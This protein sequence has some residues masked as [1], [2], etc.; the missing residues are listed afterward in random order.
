[1]CSTDLRIVSSLLAGWKD[2]EAIWFVTRQE[3][4]GPFV[5]MNPYNSAVA[6]EVRGKHLFPWGLSIWQA[7]VKIS[8]L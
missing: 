8:L 4:C 5:I 6:E 3:D 7:T 2:A 1:M